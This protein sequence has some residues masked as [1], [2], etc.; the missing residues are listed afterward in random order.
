M[1]YDYY[2]NETLGLVDCIGQCVPQTTIDSWLGDGLCDDGTW[3]V[4]LDCDEYN[5][6]GGDCPENGVA[7]I[8]GEFNYRTENQLEFLLPFISDIDNNSRDLVAFNVYRDGLFIATVESGIYE[9][10]DYD[11]VNLQE[12]CYTVTNVY[13]VGESEI[14]EDLVCTIP[15][16]G[17]APSS[18]YAYAESDYINL[19]WNPGSNLVIDYNVYRNGILYDNT[20]D[21]FYQDLNAEHDIEYCY[22]VSANYRI[23]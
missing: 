4:Y 13:E 18:L 22:V 21:I 6:D 8:G 15:I 17:L 12:Y 16:Q 9:Y 5:W 1:S 3:G 10:Y 19:E 20:T 11:V 14:L 2:Y 23:R 7:S